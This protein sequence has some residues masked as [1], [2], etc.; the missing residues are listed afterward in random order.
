MYTFSPNTLIKSSELN[1]NFAGLADGSYDDTS[2]SITT[3]RSEAMYNFVASGLVW[4]GD[5]Y[6]G[7][8]TGS[9][10]AGVVYVGGVRVVVGAVA[11]Y[12]FTASKDTY[13]D[14][15]S[16]G[17]V[18]YNAVS[19]NAA[20]PAL[21]AGSIRIAIMV[22][23]ATIAAVTSINQGQNNKTLPAASSVPYTKTDS[24]GNVICNRNPNGGLIGYRY[25]AITKSPAGGVYTYPELV[26]PVIVPTGR[27]IKVTAS[28]RF[29]ETNTTTTRNS[30]VYV[31]EDGTNITDV[32]KGGVGYNS[33][34]AGITNSTQPVAI[35]FRDLAAGLH[36]YGA[37]CYL[38]G[39]DMS[40]SGGW[41]S[42]ELV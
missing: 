4:T 22:S 2:N 28:I 14:V 39:A 19:N 27:Q 21:A 35:V 26:C 3:F 38:A 7:G 9:M 42:V 8:L 6:G 20:S 17:V 12:A 16:A 34:T 37:A 25:V 24:L 41:I 40:V 13:I 36:T 29:G 11:A 18:T 10:T 1:A 15:T 31:R 32:T 33:G 30:E 23:G 5:N